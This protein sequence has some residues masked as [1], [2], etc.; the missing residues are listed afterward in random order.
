MEPNDFVSRELAVSYVRE[1]LT[2][3][4]PRIQLISVTADSDLNTMS[5]NVVYNIKSLGMKD[6]YVFTMEKKLPEL[7]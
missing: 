1:A 4:E 2:Q 6:S 3:W 5:V 7:E